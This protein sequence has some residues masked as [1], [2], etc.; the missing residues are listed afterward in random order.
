[1]AHDG[2]GE[3]L[4]VFERGI[5]AT[6]QDGTGLGSGDQVQAG[7]RSATPG[8]EVLDEAGCVFLAGTGGPD[9][10]CNILED[11]VGYRNPGD[12][13][14]ER[15]DVL[16]ANH[17]LEGATTTAGHAAH[18]VDFLLLG[19][20]VHV[21][22]EHEAVKLRFRQGIGAFLFEGVLGSQYEERGLESEVFAP[23]RNHLFL[24]GLKE[25]RLGLGRG[26]VDFVR[27]HDVGEDRSLAEHEPALPGFRVVLEEFTTRDVGRHEVRGELDPLEGE[28][29][30]FGDGADQK[31]FSQSGNSFQESV[32]AGK[33]GNED[34]VD[35]L[36]H[37]HDALAQFVHD[38]VAG[39]IEFLD[40]GYVV[41]F[42]ILIGFDDRFFC[43]CRQFFRGCYIT[44]TF[45]RFLLLG[46][47]FGHGLPSGELRCIVVPG[48]DSWASAFGA[49]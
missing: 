6:V 41:D 29:K 42:T 47:F 8:D 24:H 3:S 32:S 2:Q 31:G 46:C 26:A 20:I 44:G 10:R 19:G 21:D 35:D 25:G 37:P 36:V 23:S 9:K 48:G 34:L 33:D 18:D 30:R 15:E 5:E 28:G 43:S 12:E 16:P 1:M 39:I 14:L 40:C 45:R 4:H 11:V 7:P 27:Q 38:R 49:G 22:L 13:I 17:F